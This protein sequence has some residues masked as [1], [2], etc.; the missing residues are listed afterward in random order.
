VVV[1]L[2]VP[3]LRRIGQ[4]LRLVHLAKEFMSLNSF[5]FTLSC[6]LISSVLEMAWKKLKTVTRLFSAASKSFTNRAL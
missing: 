1:E 2:H 3:V 4:Q 6:G 5:A